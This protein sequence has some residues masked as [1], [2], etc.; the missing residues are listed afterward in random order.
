MLFLKLNKKP[1]FLL[2]SVVGGEKW[3][4]YSFIGFDPAFIIKSKGRN[5]VLNGLEQNSFDNANPFDFLKNFFKKIQSLF[6]ARASKIFRRHGWLHI[7]R[8]CKTF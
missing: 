4:R 7:L 3:G 2:E 6:R 1:S 8:Y 5:I